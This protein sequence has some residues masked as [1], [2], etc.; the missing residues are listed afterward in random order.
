MNGNLNKNIIHSFRTQ[1]ENN[2]I[3]LLL[4]SHKD[5]LSKGMSLKD[6]DENSITVQLIGYM[7]I[8]PISADYKID[9]TRE[10]YLD[11]ALVYSGLESP[12]SSPRIDIRFMTWTSPEKFEY[13][14]E[15]KDL[16]E[17]DFTKKGNKTSTSSKRYQQRYIDTG[18]QNFINGKYYHGCLVGYIL[19][20]DPEKIADKINDLLRL[21]GRN[22]ECLIKKTAIGTIQ[23]CYESTHTSKH[24][25]SLIHYLLNLS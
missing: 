18:M 3:R 20:G 17:N 2:C 25:S 14:F 23:Y 12:D 11:S 16:Y 22:S 6:Q 9:V 4:E 10:Q 24:L 7:K 5:L 21:A 8:N 13:F 1:F 19:E 15:A